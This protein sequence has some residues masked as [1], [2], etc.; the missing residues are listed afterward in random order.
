MPKGGC[1][2]VLRGILTATLPEPRLDINIQRDGIRSVPLY[3]LIAER[4]SGARVLCIKVR[5]G[6]L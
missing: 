6:A 1:Q 5:Y 3:F 2:T 4:I